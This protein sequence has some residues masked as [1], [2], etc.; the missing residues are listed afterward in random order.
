MHWHCRDYRAAVGR[1][2]DAIGAICRKLR[3]AGGVGTD[4]WDTVARADAYIKARTPA[5]TRGWD[6]LRDMLA[7]NVPNPRWAVP[8][9]LTPEETREHNKLLDASITEEWGALLNAAEEVRIC[10]R[11]M[12]RAVVAA[13]EHMD[14]GRGMM[15]LIIRAWREVTDGI[16]AGA[17][18]W[19][20]RWAASDMGSPLARRLQFND[21]VSH[22][23]TEVGW[24]IRAVFTWMRIVRAAKVQRARRRSGTWRANEQHRLHQIYESSQTTPITT[25]IRRPYT[26]HEQT[27]IS[28]DTGATSGAAAVILKRRQAAACVHR[29]APADKKQKAAVDDDESARHTRERRVDSQLIYTTNAH[30]L[31]ID[32]ITFWRWQPRTGDG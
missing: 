15:R 19:D 3:R 11:D 21:T 7:C 29:D 12:T 2:G 22:Y 8:G 24:R 9:G 18:K 5:D 26:W 1:L 25:Q 20:Q 28:S 14:S 30:R 31:Y 10:W 16:R 27:E 4:L 6:A 32:R 23:G 17:A 13:R